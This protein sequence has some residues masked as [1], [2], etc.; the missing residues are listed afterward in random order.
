MVSEDIDPRVR[1]AVWWSSRLPRTSCV[2][3]SSSVSFDLA[4]LLGDKRTSALGTDTPVYITRPCSNYEYP[5][6][7]DIVFIFII[8]FL[9][10]VQTFSWN[11][12]TLTNLDLS[13]LKNIYIHV[14]FA[15]NRSKIFVN[16]TFVF[17]SLSFFQYSISYSKYWSVKD[18]CVSWCWL[19]YRANFRSLREKRLVSPAGDVGRTMRKERRMAKSGQW[20]AGRLGRFARA[21][22]VPHQLMPFWEPTYTRERTTPPRTPPRASSRRIS[23]R[24]L[25]GLLGRAFFAEEKFNIN[26][27]AEWR[28]VRNAPKTRQMR[29]ARITINPQSDLVDARS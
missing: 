11:S 1:Q 18:S 22:L 4:A 10:F 3:R 20:S 13:F 26:N 24:M 5:L 17:K 27:K 12:E 7:D 29:I 14:Y 21:S 16:L 9:D 23:R 6:Q 28:K 8:N 2:C 19:H 15:P 25:L